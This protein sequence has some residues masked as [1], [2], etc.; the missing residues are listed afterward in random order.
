MATFVGTAAS[1]ALVTLATTGNPVPLQAER[2]GRVIDSDGLDASS[3]LLAE[4]HLA[5]KALRLD[6]NTYVAMVAPIITKDNFVVITNGRAQRLDVGHTEGTHVPFV[7][8]DIEAVK[9]GGAS[10]WEQIGHW[11]ENLFSGS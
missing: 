11:F 8:N 5:P 3:V 6:S 1:A 7:V 10:I 4:E 2:G 9:D